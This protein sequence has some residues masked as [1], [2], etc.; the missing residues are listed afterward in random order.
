MH[1]V[2]AMVVFIIRSLINGN[3]DTIAITL[4]IGVLHN[5]L[6]LH[7]TDAVA[8]LHYLI[9]SLVAGAAKFK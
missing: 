4:S 8:C 3:I 6:Q 7:C 1:R 2:L 5:C 9:M